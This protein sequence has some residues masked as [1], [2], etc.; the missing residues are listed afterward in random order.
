[1]TIKKLYKLLDHAENIIK[2]THPE[3]AKFFP[4]E[5]SL[6]LVN[7]TAMRKLVR[8]NKKRLGDIGLREALVAVSDPRKK[9]A[10]IVVLNDRR[11]F[12]L[13]TMIHELLHLCHYFKGE[14]YRGER[15]IEA[16]THD[17]MIE[18][19]IEEN[20]ELLKMMDD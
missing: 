17:I 12:Y 14:G 1:M 2:E 11:N 18:K 4:K 13:G 10:L 6:H 8:Q 19:V 16:M 3:L 15:F 20:K 5:V 9:T 7:K